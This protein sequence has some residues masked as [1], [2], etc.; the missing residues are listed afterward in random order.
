M[1]T[2]IRV[3]AAAGGSIILCAIVTTINRTYLR[4]MVRPFPADDYEVFIYSL[5]RIG[6]LIFIAAAFAIY[7][8]IDV[9]KSRAR[10]GKYAFLIAAIALIV[11]LIL[12]VLLMPRVRFR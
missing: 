9:F 10:T 3:V 5:A 8:A 6:P 2:I 12:D 4:F 11:S 7:Y 1:S